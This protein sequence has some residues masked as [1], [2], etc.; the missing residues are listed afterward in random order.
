MLVLMLL[1]LCLWPI[2]TVPSKRRAVVLS[3]TPSRSSPSLPPSLPSFLFL[4]QVQVREAI[5]QAIDEE[6]ARDPNVFCLGEEV[7]Q[8]QGAYKVRL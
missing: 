8:Y 5:N 3:L 7:A 6:M 4:I 1:L 2:A